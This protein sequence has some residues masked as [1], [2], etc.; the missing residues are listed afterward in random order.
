MERSFGVGIMI[1]QPD[2][3]RSTAWLAR[4]LDS[5]R[6]LNDLHA[7]HSIVGRIERF[8]SNLIDI[9]LVYRILWMRKNPT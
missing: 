7:E 8:A 1:H 9:F 4:L 2:V 3:G 6:A 5:D